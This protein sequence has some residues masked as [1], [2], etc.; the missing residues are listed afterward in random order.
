MFMKDNKDYVDM[1]K[2]SVGIMLSY[3]EDSS[4]I[5]MGVFKINKFLDTSKIPYEEGMSD[6]NNT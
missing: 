3:G 2:N 1:F 6:L 4:M 5:P